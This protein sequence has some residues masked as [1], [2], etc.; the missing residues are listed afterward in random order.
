MALQVF[1][2]PTPVHI[3]FLVFNKIYIFDVTIGGKSEKQNEQT[4]KNKK[5]YLSRSI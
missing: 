3:D 5:K 1:N 4:H 2:E